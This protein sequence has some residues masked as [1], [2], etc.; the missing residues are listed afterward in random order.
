MKTK[1][2]SPKWFTFPWMAS[3]L[4]AA[5]LLLG[6]GAVPAGAQSL[7]LAPAEVQYTFKPGQPFQFELNVANNGDTAVT[8]QVNV[9]DLWYNAKN[10]K[11]FNPPGSS[12]RSAANWIEFVPRQFEAP[13]H[14]TGHVKVVV[15]PPL[16]ASGGYYAVLFVEST[17]Q[18]VSAATAEKKAVY[19][20]IRLG[21]LLLL[22]AENSDDYKVNISDFRF[23]P[24]AASQPLQL[25]FLLDNQSNTHVFPETRVAILDAGHNLIAKTEGEIKRF[26][27]QQSDRI[28]VSW[29]G[30]LPPGTYSA[31][32][33]VLYGQDKVLTQ[34]FPFVVSALQ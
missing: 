5:A 13:A 11:L 6:P 9:T 4:G 12:P 2:L 16:Q 1:S 34:E 27:P 31:I 29:A 26:L 8:M 24:P 17:P 18:L 3:M 10:E 30:S 32:L 33:T 19:A 14:G 15:T 7:A 23:T 28:S 25:D 22:N 20:N 21:S